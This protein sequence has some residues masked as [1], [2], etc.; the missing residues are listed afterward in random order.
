MTPFA[1]YKWLLSSLGLCLCVL[2]SVTDDLVASLVKDDADSVLQQVG[3]GVSP[4]EPNSKG[5][6]ALAQAVLLDSRRCA[7]VLVN[8]N[9]NATKPEPASG[10]SALTIAF[11]ASNDLMATLLLSYGASPDTA[12]GKGA[13]A[14]S[15]AKKPDMQALI[16][17]WD[18]NGAMDFEDAPGTWTRHVQ[19]SNPVPYYHNKKTVETR[20]SVPPSCAW[21]RNIL[22]GHPVYVNTVTH[23][24]VWARPPALCWKLLHAPGEHSTPYW[25]NYATEVTSVETPAELPAEIADELRFDA[26]T[27]Y[28][29]SVTQEASWEDPS[30]LSW[31]AI[32]DAAGKVFWFNPQTDE[33]TW[34]RPAD[35]AW[36]AVPDEQGHTYYENE[37]TAEVQWE[38]P[39]VIAWEKA[40]FNPHVNILS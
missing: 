36:K 12:D 37:K 20:Y 35:M 25:Y 11:S 39:V 9:A 26:G 31:R 32:K 24:A 40:Q 30:E 22:D 34:E 18:K 7:R 15:L 8:Y 27:Y 6:L 21:T 29:N 5:Q 17:R 4:N 1:R 2:G 16:D 33:K 13:T 19:D 3:H 10:M 14:R 28:H 38:K 23:Q